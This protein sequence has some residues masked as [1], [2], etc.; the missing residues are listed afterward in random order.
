MPRADVFQKVLGEQ[1]IA[2]HL[3]AA[4]PHALSWKPA[5]FNS[6]ELSSHAQDSTA[7]QR[8][9]DTQHQKG[10]KISKIIKNKIES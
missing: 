6:M 4:I 7:K 10:I 5:P 3:E 2:V 9:S 8:G 1:R